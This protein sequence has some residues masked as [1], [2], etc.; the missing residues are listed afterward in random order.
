[1]KVCEEKEYFNEKSSSCELICKIG[2]IYNPE[3]LKCQPDVKCPKGQL[4][5]NN[6]KA[7][8]SLCKN[9]EIFNKETSSCEIK[10]NNGELYD[11]KKINVL[12]YAK[13]EKFPTK[14]NHL[15]N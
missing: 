8:I 6:K 3:T 1:V 9:G 13:M 7:C 5:D 12:S 10:C 15:V 4:F 11:E 14:K 2:E